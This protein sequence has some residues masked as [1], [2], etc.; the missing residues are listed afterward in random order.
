M[1][2]GVKSLYKVFDFTPSQQAIC[3]KGKHGIGKTQII[4]NYWEARGYRVHTLDGGQLQDVG[5]IAFPALVPNA[6]GTQTLVHA[7]PDWWPKA[8]EKFVLFIDEVVRVKKTL[9]NAMMRMIL[10]HFLFEHSMSQAVGESGEVRVMCAYNPVDS[11]DG[12]YFGE[13]FDEAQKSRMNIYEFSPS[14]EEWLDWAMENPKIIH[15][16]VHKYIHQN[17][18]CLDNDG[19]CRRGW[20]RVSQMLIRNLENPDF[21]I[22]YIGMLSE[23]IIGSANASRFST[24]LR[25]YSVAMSVEDVLLGWN[26]IKNPEEKIQKLKNTDLI[27]LTQQIGLFVE[28]LI[29]SGE[30]E[31][32]KTA[33]V[34]CQKF[35]D[36]CDP[37]VQ[38]A[39]FTGLKKSKEDGKKW[40][41]QLTANNP[42]LAESFLKS[43]AQSMGLA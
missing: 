6:D 14:I 31:K 43:L 30:K 21:T 10:E 32:I 25:N 18:T 1:A 26:K 8:G 42:K 11:S 34:N 2:I 38:A 40:P 28:G 33:A 17:R 23:P 37:E 35:I 39:F 41:G 5:D 15:P 7:K 12:D 9:K 27:G 4:R 24:F 16:A 20:D 19:A 36:L 13:D 22:D 29:E 3:L